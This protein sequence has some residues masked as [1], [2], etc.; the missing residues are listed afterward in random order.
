MSASSG[1]LPRY[2][3][4]RILLVIPMM[5]ILMTMVFLLMRVAPG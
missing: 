3:L 1:S 4:Q 2:I 5:W